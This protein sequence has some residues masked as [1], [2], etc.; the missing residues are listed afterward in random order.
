MTKEEMKLVKFETMINDLYRVVFDQ[1]K[2]FRDKNDKIIQPAIIL[3]GQESDNSFIKI[4]NKTT[5]QCARCSS[6]HDMDVNWLISEARGCAKCRWTCCNLAGQLIFVS[7]LCLAI[8]NDLYNEKLEI[9]SDTA[10]LIGFNEEMIEDWIMAVKKF[11]LAEKIHYEEMKTE[12]ARRFFK[13][14]E[15]RWKS[16]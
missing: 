16:A 3:L 15:E 14:F 10:Y 2:G 6:T 8:D 7:L 11:L 5:G 12:Q 13:E 1:T 4:V 9:V